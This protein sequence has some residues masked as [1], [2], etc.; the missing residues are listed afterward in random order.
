M[1]VSDYI[2]YEKGDIMKTEGYYVTKTAQVKGNF[3]FN[4]DYMQFEAVKCAENNSVSLAYFIL[5]FS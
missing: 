4:R 5:S 3:R 2:I 1:I